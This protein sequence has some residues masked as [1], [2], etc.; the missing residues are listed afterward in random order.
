MKKTISVL[1][2]LTV[3][4][5]VLTT[6]SFADNNNGADVR[7]TG[8]D[9]TA[10]I[11]LADTVTGNHISFIDGGQDNPKSSTYNEMVILEGVNAR[12]FY[13]GNHAYFKFDEEFYDKENDHSFFIKLTLYQFGPEKGTFTFQYASQTGVQSVTVVKEKEPM[14]VTKQIYVN[15]AYFDHSIDEFNADIKI[16]SGAYNAFARLEV[17][18]AKSIKYDND[19]DVNMLVSDGHAKTLEQLGLYTPD[20]DSE[21][22]LKDE[23]TKASAAAKIVRIIGRDKEAQSCTSPMSGATEEEKHALGYLAD[24]GYIDW[25][26]NAD[27]PITQTELVKVF[28]NIQGIS[29][30]GD[31]IANAVDK[32]VLLS[33]DMMMQPNKTAIEDNLLALGYNW[34]LLPGKHGDENIVDMMNGGLIDEE[35]LKNASEVRLQGLYYIKPRKIEKHEVIDPTTGR[36]YYY[37][38]R[39]NH[40]LIREYYTTN[41]WA[42]DNKRFIVQDDDVSAPKYLYDTEKGTLQYLDFCYNPAI[43]IATD[44]LY[45]FKGRNV[46]KMN[47]NTFEK[48]LVAPVY[49]TWGGSWGTSLTNDEKYLA[50]NV[51]EYSDP[52]DLATPYRGFRGRRVP[53]LNLE[54]GEWNTSFHKE[55]IGFDSESMV[56]NHIILNPVYDNL[57]FFAHEGNAERTPDRIWLLDLNTNKA[58]NLFRQKQVSEER[59][60]EPAGHEMWF[61]NGERLGYVKYPKAGNI[62]YSGIMTIDLTGKHKEYVNSDYQYWHCCASPA[63]DRFIVADTNNNVGGNIEIVLIDRYTGESHLLCK[64][65]LGYWQHPGHAQPSFSQDGR[66]VHFVIGDRN[67][68]IS[69]AWMDVS[70]IVDKPA[71]GGR[72]EISE[73]CEGPS[74]KGTKN[75]FEKT[76]I[77]GFDCFKIPAG[78]KM[79]VN[80]KDEKFQADRVDATI[81]FDYYDWGYTPVRLSY[82]GWNNKSLFIDKTEQ[83]KCEVARNS[84]KQWKTATFELK[85]I[86]L[87]NME[88]IGTDFRIEGVYADLYVKDLK[89]EVTNVTS[90]FM[91]Q[92]SQMKYFNPDN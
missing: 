13:G 56:L 75:Y 2:I 6:G 84:T 60:G 23:L 1:L 76:K 20:K 4:L 21:N 28:A 59:T 15:D 50:V 85:D 12:K 19:F 70:D 90:E 14:W 7:D 80:V 64:P 72:T 51:T 58:F 36:K 91:D 8:D 41:L 66:Q 55:F 34:L 22:F 52:L 57:V 3:L 77:G 92:R 33:S 37:I 68:I 26:G 54:T 73:L 32:G 5:G 53:V 30:E 31:V 88:Y 62:A 86:N 39:G 35:K 38:N 49:D 17:V 67:G 71:I 78:K 89:V 43:S 63:N 48:E 9:N 29:T 42:A 74:Y 81:S 87:D 79:L 65:R 83:M 46:W 24:N 25:S 69:T 10:W 47:L 40:Q 11:R 18:N 45:Y 61:G 16:V 27:E 82:F 44:N